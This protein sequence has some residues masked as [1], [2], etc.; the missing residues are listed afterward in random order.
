MTIG[1]IL[2]FFGA[3][4]PEN[5][6]RGKPIAALQRER[7]EEGGWAESSEP[8]SN[9]LADFAAGIVHATQHN[10][11][12]VHRSNKHRTISESG[13]PFSLLFAAKCSISLV[14]VCT[15]TVYS[16]RILKPDT[17][18]DP[19][20]GNRSRDLVCSSPDQHHLPS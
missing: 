14:L 18:A 11:N 7:L 20:G 17:C 10:A 5:G 16:H 1:T 19:D 3:A 9:P 8:W 6:H 12:V 4:V 15:T 2:V 13:L